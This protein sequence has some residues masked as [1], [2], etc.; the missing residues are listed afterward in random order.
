ME[1]RVPLEHIFLPDV[2][3]DIIQTSLTLN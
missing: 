3:F 2:F 1:S